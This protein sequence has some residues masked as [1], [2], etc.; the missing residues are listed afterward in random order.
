MYVQLIPLAVA[1]SILSATPL[2]LPNRRGSLKF[3][4]LGDFGTGH[5]ASRDVAAQMLQ[6]QEMTEDAIHGTLSA[7]NPSG[8]AGSRARVEHG[9]RHA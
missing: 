4:V 7:I 2:R 6:Q 9:L 1:A 8:A 3:A 5:S